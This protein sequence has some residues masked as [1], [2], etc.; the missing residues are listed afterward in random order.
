M[1]GI[2][3][4]MAE[5]AGKSVFVARR[6][7]SGYYLDFFAEDPVTD[8]AIRKHE[9]DVVIF[10]GGCQTAAYPETHHKLTAPSEASAG[11]VGQPG[12]NRRPLA[13][14]AVGGVDPMGT[15]Y[16]LDRGPPSPLR[17]FLRL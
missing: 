12:S 6:V 15:A 10:S 2:F 13:K 16:Y 1:P 17:T 11:A 8:Q 5:A 4:D 7:Q 9:W 14:L 3:E